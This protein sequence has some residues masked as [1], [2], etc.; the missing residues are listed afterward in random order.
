MEKIEVTR[1][2]EFIKKNN[3]VIV[4]GREIPLKRIKVSRLEPRKEELGLVYGSVWSFPK[5]G[6]WASHRSDYRGNWPPQLPRILIESYTQ[7][8]DSVLDPMVGSGTT[9]IEALLLKRRCI[10][11]DIN[12]QSLVLAWHRL[13][14]LSEKLSPDNPMKP[15]E[16]IEL[17]A[18]DARDLDKVQENEVK[19]VATHPPYWRSLK[20]STNING[21]L[22]NEKSLKRYLDALGIISNEIYRVLVPGG[23]FAILLGDSRRKRHYVPVSIYALKKI[24]EPGF[25]L[26]E[27]I[28]KIQ[29]KIKD[30][31]VYWER[32]SRDFLMIKHEK[33]YIMRKPVY[34]GEEKKYRYSTMKRRR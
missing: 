28:V 31:Q 11:V 14:A 15:L 5:R 19:L 29:H 22:S 17:Y 18:G 4:G 12:V 3:K 26:M 30:T 7:Q 34:E 13:Y 6:R 24:L 25:I 32:Y 20:Y 9:C 16:A 1:Y 23:V 33:L 2:F 27:E 10:G 21:D 8:G